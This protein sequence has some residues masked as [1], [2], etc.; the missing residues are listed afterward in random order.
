M[1][2]PLCESVW[3]SDAVFSGEVLSVE[4]MSNAGQELFSSVRVRF[5]VLESWRG[6]VSNV[7]EIKTGM[8]GGDCGYSFRERQNYLVYAHARGGGLITSICSRTRPLSQA[9]EDVAYLKTAAS[10]QSAAGRIFGTVQYQWQSS[11]DGGRTPERPISD[12]AVTLSDGKQTWKTVTDANGRFEFMVPA[13]TYTVTLTTPG[14][15]RG[16][17]P[18]NVTL[19]VPRGCAAANFYVAPDR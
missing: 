6:D 12:Y 5:K 1:G 15:E 19:S 17:G 11:P 10:T 16:G 8:G 9:A 13:G 14:N 2:I 7:V 18:R 3:T 4:R